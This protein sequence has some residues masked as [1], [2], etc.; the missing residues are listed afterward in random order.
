MEIAWRP[1]GASAH[2]I[3]C[4]HKCF[5]YQYRQSLC[6]VKLKET[7]RVLNVRRCIENSKL[8]C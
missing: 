7:I 1:T 3:L 2:T 4:F 8:W 6:K 5:E